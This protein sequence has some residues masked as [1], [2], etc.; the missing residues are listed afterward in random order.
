MIVLYGNSK[1]GILS[2][3]KH[4]NANKQKL[5]KDKRVVT[6]FRH[7]D[8][9]IAKKQFSLSISQGYGFSV[10]KFQM[11]GIVSIK[12]KRCL[13]LAKTVRK[14]KKILWHTPIFW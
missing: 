8:V 6:D 5:T 9:R 13:S 12:S 2:L 10:R 11:Q 4:G 7:L 14:L 1:G 3:L